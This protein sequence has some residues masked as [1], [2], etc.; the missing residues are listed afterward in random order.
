MRRAVWF[1]LG[2]AVAVVVVVKGAQ[3]L[4]KATPEGVRE[5]VADASADLGQ[6]ATTFV[7]TLTS[8]MAERETE[9]RAALGIDGADAMERPAAAPAR[10]AAS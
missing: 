6:R 2:A 4:R 1:A 3:L 9:L 7:R 5:Q 8:A 10:R